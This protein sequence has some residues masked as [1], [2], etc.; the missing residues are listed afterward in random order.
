MLTRN[1]STPRRR[2]KLPSG[3]TLR[4]PLF[5]VTTDCHGR[6]ALTTGKA[7]G[8]GERHPERATPSLS[9]GHPEPVEGPPRA[10]S[11]TL[12]PFCHPERSE[13]SKIPAQ[14]NP[15]PRIP[16]STPITTGI[17]ACP[18]TPTAQPHQPLTQTP[19]PQGLLIVCFTLRWSPQICFPRRPSPV[20]PIEARNLKS[21]PIG[22]VC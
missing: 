8:K 10:P 6:P 17:P 5:K 13:G 16:A 22:A 1:P 18:P 14:H 4:Q 19:Q 15:Q 20:I 11:V 3:E 2:A 12:S 21:F 7:F 9:K